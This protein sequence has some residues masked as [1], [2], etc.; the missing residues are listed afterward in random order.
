MRGAPFPDSTS[1]GLIAVLSTW[2]GDFWGKP[3]LQT[4]ELA[5]VTQ[6]R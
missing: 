6:W 1:N 3:D 5:N 2:S 4:G